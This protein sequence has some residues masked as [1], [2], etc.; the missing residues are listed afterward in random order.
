MARL[1]DSWHLSLPA[2]RTLRNPKRLVQPETVS[3]TARR[4]ISA[5]RGSIQMSGELIRS[6]TSWRT[7]DLV[8]RSSMRLTGGVQG[9]P[10][11]LS[12]LVITVL[13]NHE[14]DALAHKSLDDRPD[15]SL[16]QRRA[17]HS[18]IDQLPAEKQERFSVTYG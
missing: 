14:W 13:V 7:C 15:L 18:G 12:D 1:R 16:L 17:H 11:P 5:S 2:I 9:I 8:R 3:I 10:E 4:R 6:S